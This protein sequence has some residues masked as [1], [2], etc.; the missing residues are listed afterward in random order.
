MVGNIDGRASPR[1]RVE[2]YGV[3]GRPDT[4]VL[5][6][7]IV[8]TGFT[9]AISI[10][11]AQA[12]PLGLLLYSTAIF[13][14]ADNSQ[15]HTFLC[16]GKARFDNEERTIV[17]SLTKGNDILVGTEFLRSFNSKLELDYKMNSFQISVQA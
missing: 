17:F 14:L 3:M 7:A 8:D 9:G 6:D 12:L 15:E 16:I 10:P 11:I 4:P 2:L 1:I 5:F 13:T